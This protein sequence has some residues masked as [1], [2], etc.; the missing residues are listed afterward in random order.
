MRISIIW[1]DDH[2][3]SV[4]QF[5]RL[6]VRFHV[7]SFEREAD[8]ALPA[9]SA[10]ADLLPEI[11][12]L[13]G[14]PKISRPWQATTAAGAVIDPAVPLHATG[15]DHGAVLVF[16]PHHGL[17]APVVRDAAESLADAAVGP[18]A[19]G[20][21]A[22]GAMAGCLGLVT[23][24]W[25]VQPAAV[26]LAAGA[27][28]ALTVLVWRRE[29]GILAPLAVVLAAAAA[30]S[31]VLAAA[32]SEAGSHGWAGLSAGVAA[33]VTLV[34]TVMLGAAGTRTA[35]GLAA[36]GSLGTLASA[37]MFLPGAAAGGV[38][39]LAAPAALVVV[40]G[41]LL[42]NT[43]PGLSMRAAGLRV[44]RLPTAGQDLAVADD[45]P[46]DVDD[47]ARRALLLHEGMAVGATVVMTPALL[48]VG[49]AGGGFPQGL[50]AATAGALL[51]HAARHR[52]A[53]PAWAW[54]TV[55]LAACLGVC[56]AATAGGGHPVQLI[57]AAAVSLSGITAP[58]WAHRVP[59]LEPTAVVWWERA[60]SLAVAATLP[61]AAHLAGL[62]TLIRGLG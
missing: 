28:A 46:T 17:P 38:G 52:H 36:A 50:C 53:V 27:L 16:T 61:L 26:A 43:A 10:L 2:T 49:V 30:A 9:G 41:L 47:R 45:P 31:A 20:L 51:L 7:G 24:L 60:E 39:G 37:G 3:V 40:G 55:G 23:V 13:C 32:P 11:W 25:A 19:E 58:L 48:A 44:P 12:R 35:G 22:A 15:L 34:A 29:V 59:E 14:A 56:L 54:L 33:L 21:A 6:T 18:P 57:T 1:G 5:L 42:V 8:L 62:F 4:D